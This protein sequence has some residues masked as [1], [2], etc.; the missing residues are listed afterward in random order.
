LKTIVKLIAVITAVFI[1]A[2]FISYRVITNYYNCEE[3]MR[4]VVMNRITSDVEDR[5]EK[6]SELSPDMIPDLDIYSQEYVK[7]AIP[8]EIR[9]VSINAIPHRI[10]A[11]ASYIQP[12]FEP[13]RDS[14]MTLRGF[15]YFI[16]S[17]NNRIFTIE[18][19]GII[20]LISYFAVILIILLGY[21][22]MIRPFNRLSEYPEKIAKGRIETGIPESKQR[23]F[24]KY[25][26]GMNMLKDEMKHKEN[27]L[28]IMEKEK[29]TLIISIAHGIKTPLSNIKLYAE[30]IERGIYHEDKKPNEKDA[31]TAAKISRNVE[32]V[33]A[34]VKDIMDKSAEYNVDYT[35]K[36]E[37]FYL[38]ELMKMVK[39][40]YSGRAE[41][42]HIPFETV[43]ENNPLVTSDKDGIYTIISQLMENAIKYGSGQGISVI[44]G[45]QDEDVFITVK[46]KGNVLSEEETAYVFKSF[47]RGSNSHSTEGQG[48]GLYVSRKIAEALSGDIFMKAWEAEDTTEVTLIIPTNIG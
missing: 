34:L 35:P 1:L 48:I 38:E 30:A 40:E 37:S 31:E 14:N 42:L 19:T 3:G 32:K 8:D 24:G 29:Q 15:L 25:V 21:H 41:L 43:C 39:K 18:M 10:D 12:V 11:D 46:N 17:S 4:T 28:N 36:I 16:Y 44:M 5:L 20:L 13:S 2:A 23:L 26:W 33:E 7:K 27:S 6:D 22:T 9:I 45:R 47:W